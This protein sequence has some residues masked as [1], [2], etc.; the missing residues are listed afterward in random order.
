MI[1]NTQMP[2][3][4]L[5]G[6]KKRKAKEISLQDKQAC[7]L[8]WRRSGLNKSD[9]CHQRRMSTA[10]FYRW[11]KEL[12]P[13]TSPISE[14]TFVPVKLGAK[15]ET[16]HVNEETLPLTTDNAIDIWLPNGI[17]LRISTLIALSPLTAFI[18]ELSHE[19]TLS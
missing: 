1:Q 16:A 12:G 5:L 15:E 9:F 17:R 13:I 3:N 10:T 11:M 18:R 19:N 2:T 7:L 6:I 14:P 4:G 8:D